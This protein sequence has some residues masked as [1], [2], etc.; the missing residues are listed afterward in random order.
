MWRWL[1]AKE[2]RIRLLDYLHF[3]YKLLFDIKRF[4]FILSDVYEMVTLLL[5]VYGTASGDFYT[6]VLHIITTGRNYF[7]SPSRTHV[8]PIV[9]HD[10][11]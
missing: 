6:F 11:I 3:L 10:N 2:S 1:P 4:V 8:N 9:P 5:D 7:D